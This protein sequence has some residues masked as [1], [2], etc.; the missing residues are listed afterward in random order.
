MSKKPNGRFLLTWNDK[1]HPEITAFFDEIE[2]GLYSHTLRK[3]IKLYM[4]QKGTGEQ[5][6]P[7]NDKG[8]LTEGADGHNYDHPSND[9]KSNND[10]YGDVFDPHSMLKM[11][12]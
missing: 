6:N 5:S 2:E 3:V 11:S 1:K 10:D 12:D 7:V 9:E 8:D 4:E